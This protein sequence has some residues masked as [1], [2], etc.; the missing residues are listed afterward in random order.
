MF[1][2]SSNYPGAPL[3]KVQRKLVNRTGAA[4][5]PGSLVA[6]NTTVATGVDGQ[7]FGGLNPS[8]LSDGSG[9]GSLYTG[10]VYGSAISP[11]ATNIKDRMAVVPWDLGASVPDGATF[12][13]YFQ[14][15]DGYVL[16]EGS[17]GVA[18]DEY[19][20]G[21]SGQ[22]YG[23]GRTRAELGTAG[24]DGEASFFKV[25]G[26]TRAAGPSGAAGLTRCEFW[27]GLPYAGLIVGIGSDN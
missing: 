10:Y 11:T 22:V 19:I 23:T 21:T 16:M 7:N 25:L 24:T 20:I 5:A 13:A 4:L 17:S 6:F 14:F 2:I 15:E 3:M 8:D 12:D 26:K 18:R 27:G 9:T 1:D